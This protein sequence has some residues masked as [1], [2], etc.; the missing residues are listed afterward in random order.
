MTTGTVR[1]TPT[2]KTPMDI[3]PF[4]LERY[5][6]E[7]EYSVPHLLCCSDCETWSIHDLLLLEETATERFMGLGLGYSESKGDPLLRETIAE[8]YETAGARDILVFNGAEEAIYAFAHAVLSPGDHVIVHTPCY[9]SLQEV[10]R[11]IGCD[12]TE[13][14]AGPENDW[15]PDLDG[16]KD[17]VRPGT[18]AL[19]CNFPHNPSGALPPRDTLHEIRDI[20]ADHGI[21]VFSDEVYRLLEYSEDNRLPAFCDIDERSLSLGVVSKSFGLAGLRVGWA[22]SKNRDVLGAMAS[23]RDYTTICNCA[24]GEF[25]A[26]LAIR[27][28]DFLLDANRNIIRENLEILDA[29]FS[30]YDDVFSWKRPNAGPVAFPELLTGGNADDLCRRLREDEKV[31]LLPG[32]VFGAEY[33]RFFR[34]GFGRKTMKR[35]LERFE[36][37]IRR[38]YRSA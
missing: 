13:W 8:L 23:F 4:A 26:A 15:L 20:A 37:F 21:L 34:V 28:R 16:L 33:D 18:K 6:A 25:L 17:A 30:R 24:P 11:S 35:S 27:N 5:F 2:R 3:T 38:E 22:A 10:A 9:Q 36:R 1:P 12:I 7:Y 31:L 19:I 32:S 14:R 29:F